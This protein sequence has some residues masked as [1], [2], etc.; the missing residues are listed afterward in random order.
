MAASFTSCQNSSSSKDV[1][2]ITPGVYYFH[3]NRRCAT[4]EAVETVTKATVKENFADSIP[5]FII[6]RDKDE[7]KE[8]AEK[9]NIT[10]Q[11]LLIVNN[12]TTN[13]L[14]NSAFLNARSN[15]DKFKE[16]LIAGIKEMF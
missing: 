12:S 14:T 2:A 9:L 15:P 8:L 4:C 1:L 5:V 3:G 10:G 11:T 16:E 7:N 6:N 13:N